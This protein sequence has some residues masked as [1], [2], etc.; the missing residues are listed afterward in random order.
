LKHKKILLTL[1]PALIPAAVFA[2]GASPIL[3][4]FHKDT[5][6]MA[7]IVTL[8]IILIES[9]LLKWRVKG[10]HFKRALWISILINIASS[11]TGSLLLLSVS[12]DSFFVEDDISFVPYL[13]F[14][15][16]LTEI[17]LL[18][19]LLKKE[20]NAIKHPIL[21]GIGIN[22]ASYAA[23]FIIEIGLLAGTMSYASHL[24]EKEQKEW[25]HPELLQK[26]EGIIFTSSWGS[27]N[28]EFRAFNPRNATWITITNSPSLSYLPYTWDV[29]GDLIAFIKTS[30]GNEPHIIVNRLPKLEQLLDL[31]LKSLSIPEAKARSGIAG[32]A[33]SP[34]Q[35]KI[36]LLVTIG[37]TLAPKDKYSHY[38]LGYSCRL[39]VVDAAS[40][41]ILA[42]APRKASNRGLCWLAD[43]THILFT[44][45][46][47]KTLYELTDKDIQGDISC[48]SDYVK[49]A[50]FQQ[51]I[52][53]FDI[54]SGTNSLY[55]TP[56]FMPAAATHTNIIMVQNGKET[57]LL[58]TDSAGIIKKL[59][60]NSELSTISPDGK[61]ILKLSLMYNFF[62]FHGN[63][64]IS[65]LQNPTIRHIIARERLF[66]IDWTDTEPEHL[67]NR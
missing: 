47:D 19:M 22:I 5:W 32:I 65:E 54:L 33:I 63:L 17:P 44:S 49:D 60:G 2:D 30:D 55:F 40:G 6:P 53:K 52:Y 1:I 35:N 36:A 24:D 57:L 9:G 34:D 64:T 4:F 10:I 21:L 67:P 12:R 11:T 28:N 15:T 39:I 25:N 66:G 51:G 41:R 13:F 20:A 56:G 14:I 58:D 45:F 29:Q 48:G 61:L 50:Q 42:K 3:N 38:D 26:A 7:S 18:L 37:R 8:V 31:P 43:S 27:S 62:H 46:D 59:S 23:I 16:L